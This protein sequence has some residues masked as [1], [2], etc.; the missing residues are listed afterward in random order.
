VAHVIVLGGGFGGLAAAHEL[1][2]LLTD[3]HDITLVARD[4]R[5]FMGFAKLW[6]LAGVRPL[7]KGTRP[8]SAVGR[9]G[10]QFHHAE[11]T[12]IDPERRAVS[13]D[14][15]ELRGD[16]L[17]VALGAPD[18]AQQSARLGGG[19]LNLYDARSLP[20]IHSALEELNTGRIL[21]AVMGTPFKCPPAPFEA[22]FIVDERL[23]ARGVRD[24]VEVV[25][26][27]PLPGTLPV[28]GP[29]ASR[30]LAGMLDERR[31]GLLLEHTVAH[32][33]RADRRATFTAGGDMEYALL[34]TVPRSVPPTVVRNSAL[35][36]PSGWIEPDRATLR[37]AFNR[38][39]AVGDCTLIETA[40]KPLPKAGVFA[41]A[42]GL[43]A[44]RNIAA[45][46][47]GG[48]PATFDGHGHC[49]LELPGRRVATVEGDFFAEPR[50]DVVL[51]PPD[52]ATFEAKQ[53]FERDRLEA[54]LGGP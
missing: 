12:A 21:I 26:A 45:E 49:Y 24:R 25:V 43:V 7:E 41:E 18:D 1:R 17:L 51:S 11:V 39:Y 31:I 10:I 50:P 32:V 42:E 5:F 3:R 23:R 34:L 53:R 14:D 16:A 52:E 54:W 47:V 48:D 36:G 19:A 37:T 30:Y 29:E 40:A 4:D 46:L 28:A 33:D 13:T 44:A 22:A 15:G 9:H 8:L 6:D 38:V 20:A 2:R 27:T 35:A